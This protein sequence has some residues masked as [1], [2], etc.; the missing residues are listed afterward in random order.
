MSLSRKQ[1]AAFLIAAT[2][3]CT[4]QPT[5]PS[6]G[7]AFRITPVLPAGSTLAT[8]N[9]VV[10]SVFVEI[11]VFDTTGCVECEGFRNGPGGTAP[12]AAAGRLDTILVAETFYW[13]PADQSLPL[14]FE[15]PEIPEHHVFQLYLQMSAGPS[16]LFYGYL[17]LN[18]VRGT[19]VLPPI[20]VVYIGPG[21]LADSLA[22]TP[23]DTSLSLIDTLNFSAE[24]FQSGA[25][26]DTAY[27]GWRTTD[28]TKAQITYTGQLTFRPSMAGSTVGVI[29]LVPNG[30]VA[31]TVYVTVPQA[32]AVIQRV[33]GDSQ[34]APA[35]TPLPAPLVVR[36]L[37]AGGN[38]EPG[39]LVRFD[40]LGLT[41]TIPLD[42]LVFTDS[43]GLASTTILVGAVQGGVDI[44]AYVEAQSSIKLSFHATI[45]PPAPVIWVS[46]SFGLIGSLRRVHSD[47]SGRATVSGLSTNGIQQSLP[48][49]APGYKRAAYSADLGN[50]RGINLV[51]RVGDS[52]V[53]Y[54]DD[55]GANRPR[56][57][58]D[59][60]HIA[61]Q[62]GGIQDDEQTGEV[63]V[64]GGVSGPLNTLAGAGNTGSRVL[65]TDQVAGRPTGPAS[66]AWNPT[67]PT[68]IA[69]VR[70]LVDSNFIATS[71]I[72]RIDATGT[73]LALLSPDTIDL[74]AGPLHVVGPMDWSP[75]GSQIV[76]SAR[77]PAEQESSLYLLDVST[78][79]TTRLTTTPG[80]SFG[81]NGDRLPVFSPDGSEVL[82]LRVDH[83]GDGMGAD[84]HVVT[85]A[86]GAVRQVGY[87]GSAWQSSDL[88]SLSADWS[89]DGNTLLLPGMASFSSAL[90]LVP[91]STS[92]NA[93]YLASRVRIGD[94]NGANNWSDQ[95]G[96]WR[97]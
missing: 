9:L 27:I 60:Q 48:R 53:T 28:P 50:N 40:P 51:N 85:V 74:G 70:D 71:A 95:V 31:E 17:D 16:V 61:F 88:Y 69:I 62:C 12:I 78:G 94:A 76:F 21:F 41:G 44:E 25:P 52:S 67:E 7:E 89:L 90:Y 3:A 4:D 38:P 1:L 11:Y 83:S 20:N 36:V 22:V 29:A 14:S 47:L 91:A 55:I 33:S 56:F 64:G 80:G 37:D 43:L 18:P 87:E 30:I 46:D 26:L 68:E 45:D 72:Y 49:W 57:S 15:L 82:F 97:P 19:V 42:S 10:D 96:S 81:D 39:V 66:Y 73:G 34:I 23:G 59:G 92:T 32:A 2:L 5:E 93:E 58:P 24:A 13:D 35:L 75:D 63:C 84:W 8:F 77:N 86:G 79:V 54:V 6:K 65:L